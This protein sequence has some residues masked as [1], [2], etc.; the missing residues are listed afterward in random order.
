MLTRG[1]KDGLG[2]LALDA[3]SIL[4]KQSQRDQLGRLGWGAARKW[5]TEA[6]RRLA[7]SSTTLRH[8]GALGAFHAAASSPCLLLGC[9]WA[10]SAPCCCSRS[11]AATPDYPG[12]VRGVRLRGRC[13]PAAPA[14]QL[15]SAPAVVTVHTL[16]PL[17][18][19]LAAQTCQW[20]LP[21]QPLTPRQSAH[22]LSRC[23][24]APR[25]M[26]DSLLVPD[27]PAPATTGIDDRQADLTTVLLFMVPAG[28]SPRMPHPAC[29]RG[30]PSS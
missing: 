18:P 22:R 17:A 1:C 6:R 26:K 25:R 2:E 10:R 7:T 13:A 28:T 11:H 20:R 8:M 12:E 19:C 16:T 27:L 29:M 21:L 30:L 23:V 9:W 5:G 24:A 15:P 4:K 3:L 14:A